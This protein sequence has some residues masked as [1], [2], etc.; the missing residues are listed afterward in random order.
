MT[1]VEREYKRLKALFS[2]MDEKQQ[3]AWDGVCMEA[4]ELKA[5]LKK[6]NAAARKSG[7]VKIDPKNPERQKELPV[8]KMITR[9]SAN[10]LSYMSRIAHALGKPVQEDEDD[11]FEEEYG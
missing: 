7:L 10:Y 4:A 3:A 5:Q 2:D 9:I 11:S 8:S 1:E 6:L